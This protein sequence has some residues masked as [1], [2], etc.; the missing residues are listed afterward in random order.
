MPNWEGSDRKETLPPDWE[1][2]RLRVLRRDRYRCQHVRYD[3]GRKCAAFANQVDHINDR[4]DHDERNLQSLC[5]WHHLRKSGSQ[6]GTAA[7]E[8]RQA[9]EASSKPRHPGLRP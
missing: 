3:T 1:K 7:A 5:E 6:G 4:E 2:R 9:R 8:A